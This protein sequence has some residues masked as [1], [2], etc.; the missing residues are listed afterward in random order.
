VRGEAEA[1]PGAFGWYI[2][3]GTMVKLVAVMKSRSLV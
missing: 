1:A 2:E 3:L